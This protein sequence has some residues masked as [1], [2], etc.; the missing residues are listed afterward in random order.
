MDVCVWYLYVC[1]RVCGR[2]CVC[3]RVCSCVCVFVFNF[4][5]VLIVTSAGR[6]ALPRDPGVST[7][8][9]WMAQV[10][11]VFDRRSGARGRVRHQLSLN[12]DRGWS[13]RASELVLLLLY[14]EYQQ[15]V[16]VSTMHVTCRPFPYSVT[17]AVFVSGVSMQLAAFS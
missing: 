16:G 8:P 12:N 5:C 10:G 3:A 4:V 13:T 1:G 17:N 2:A 14:I 15:L 11:R 9:G 6:G 7:T